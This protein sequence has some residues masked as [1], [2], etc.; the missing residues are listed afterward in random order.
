MLSSGWGLLFLLL[1][2]FTAAA[3]FVLLLRCVLFDLVFLALE[4][5]LERL[6]PFPAVAKIFPPYHTSVS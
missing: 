2:F 6:L 3:L 5:A 4:D 1:F